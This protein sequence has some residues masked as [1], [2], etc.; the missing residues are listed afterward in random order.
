VELFSIVDK[1][2]FDES[3][4][5]VGKSVILWRILKKINDDRLYR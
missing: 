5:K 1:K 3:V 2:V 4:G